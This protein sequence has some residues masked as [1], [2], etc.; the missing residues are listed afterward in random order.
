M[1]SG[2]PRGLPRESKGVSKHSGDKES[3]E[4]TKA[5]KTRKEE[6]HRKEK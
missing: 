1:W 4:V 5:K 2:Q 6:N 3:I